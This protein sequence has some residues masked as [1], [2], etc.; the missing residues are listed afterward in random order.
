MMELEQEIL[1]AFA[2]PL[3]GQVAGP[4]PLSRLRNASGGKA[5]GVAFKSHVSML[6]FTDLLSRF[7]GE[8]K[9]IILVAKK[10]ACPYRTSRVT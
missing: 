9:S 2:P 10:A 8:N 7:I 5:T 1:K 6:D 3:T 4:L